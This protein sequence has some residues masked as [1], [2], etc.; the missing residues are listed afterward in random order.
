MELNERASGAVTVIDLKG[1]LV[2][3][4][5]QRLKDKVNSLV[6]QGRTWIVLNLGD[7][8]HIDSTGLGEI[9]ACLTTVT[10]A[11]GN[12]KLSNVA[13]RNQDLLS[14]TRLATVFETFDSEAEAVRS[15]GA[16]AGA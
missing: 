1:R 15:F 16:V 14:I 9:V 11:G 8:S 12:I 10:R 13:K 5:A 6:F 7:M 2:A 4:G 3:E